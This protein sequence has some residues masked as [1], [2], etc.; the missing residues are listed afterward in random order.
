M[1][2]GGEGNWHPERDRAAG[3]QLAGA[4]DES[5]LEASPPVAVEELPRQLGV[6]VAPL[7]RAV[8]PG[9]D[10][11][12]PSTTAS[13][14]VGTVVQAGSRPPPA[15][16]GAARG[17]G[18]DEHLRV[19]VVELDHVAGADRRSQVKERSPVRR[20]HGAR[21][22][23]LRGGVGDVL[24]DDRAGEGRVEGRDPESALRR[25]IDRGD[26]RRRG[27]D[28]EAM[29]DSGERVVGVQSQH[30]ARASRAGHVLG[31]TAEAAQ[32]AVGGGALKATSPHLVDAVEVVRADDAGCRELLAPAA[33]GH[34]RGRRSAT[35]PAGP[36]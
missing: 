28:D 32:E 9:A 8:A 26:L 18:H 14:A 4:V 16:V 13:P 33:P 20:A 5:V 31:G 22:E 23:D 2:V 24:V 35:R 6:V 7:E 21:V 17:S 36:G 27:A 29:V 3:G 11:A 30:P 10:V 15:P 19:A 34:R 1:S 25:L 12:S